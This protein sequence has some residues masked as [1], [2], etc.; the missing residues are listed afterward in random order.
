MELQL[1]NLFMEKRSISCRV[2]RRWLERHVKIIYGNIYPDQ[3]IRVEGEHTT[4]E[5][6]RFSDGWFNGFKMRFNIALRVRNYILL[7][8][9]TN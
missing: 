4:Y 6:F 3:A 8:T 1:H 5:G 9:T 7:Q 2:G